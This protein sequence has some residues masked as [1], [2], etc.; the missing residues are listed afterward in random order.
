MFLWCSS[1]APNSYLYM[2]LVFP[3]VSFTDSISNINI[4][5][6]IN[7]HTWYLIINSSASALDPHCLPMSLLWNKNAP[8]ESK[9]FLFRIFPF[10]RKQIHFDR[11][12]SPVSISIRL[13]ISYVLITVITLNIRQPNFR[14]LLIH[15]FE[16]LLLTTSAVSQMF[17][18]W[19][20][21]VCYQSKYLEYLW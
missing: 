4:S 9:C 14:T 2:C 8:F 16:Q 15:N 20:Y 12:A 1:L 5:L 6:K 18:C 19:V 10:R 13:T 21:T 7:H 11:V 17:W 3:R